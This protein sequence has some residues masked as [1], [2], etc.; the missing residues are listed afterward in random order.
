MKHSIQQWLLMLNNR[1][2]VMVFGGII[3]TVAIL[4]WGVV[5]E[6]MKARHKKLNTQIEEKTNELRWMQLSNQRI[7]QAQSSPNTKRKPI[8]T[9]KAPRPIIDK[10]LRQFQLKKGLK[11]MSGVKEVSVNLKEIQADNLMKFLGMLEMKYGIHVLSMDITP[12]NDN[13][14]INASLKLGR[15]S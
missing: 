14:E 15:T 4:L 8:N 3:F 13:G 7:K 11:N 5:Y 10:A 12:K 1:E 9:A 2:K 6:P